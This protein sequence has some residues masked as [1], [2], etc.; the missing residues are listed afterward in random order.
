MALINHVLGFPCLNE[1]MAPLQQTALFNTALAALGVQVTRSD[2]PCGPVYVQRRGFLPSL[3]SRAPACIADA[4]M[5]PRLVNAE[6]RGAAAALR[7]CGYTAIL[8]PA[9]V[10][11]LDLSPP[12]PDLH[13]ALHGKWRNRLTTARKRLSAS[14]DVAH[15]AF[16]PA[17][18]GWLLKAE[19]AQQR[20]RRYR[21]YPPALTRL[22][23]EVEPKALRLFTL[24]E[25]RDP[26]A[27]MLFVRHGSM[28][29]YHIGWN[30]PEGRKL[31]AHH[32]LL[33]EAIRAL[34]ARGVQMLDL[35]TV[36][37]ERSAGLAR[38]KLGSGAR[39]RPLGGTWLRW[40]Q[41]LRT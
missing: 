5:R 13:A 11:E 40:R 30:S 25:R 4:P 28:A 23:H 18:D 39:A 6:A 16:D 9:H 14:H 27:A 33:W 22:M 12:L 37:T 29:T 2:A 7:A 15:R 26:I 20:T 38:F 41:S 21:G 1:H 34:R 3:A 19:A 36:E 10:A 35:G 32:L 31:A 17:R 8:T 24:H